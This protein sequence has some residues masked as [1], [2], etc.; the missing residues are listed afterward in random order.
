MPI[1]KRFRLN[2]V[3]KKGTKKSNCRGRRSDKQIESETLDFNLVVT[4]SDSLVIR[5]TA[6]LVSVW[7]RGL[8]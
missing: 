5:V 8:Y 2:K 1:G 6:L 4:P 3:Y 7:K